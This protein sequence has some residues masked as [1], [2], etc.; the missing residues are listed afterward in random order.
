MSVYALAETPEFG[1]LSPK[2]A[3]FLMCYVQGF[4]NT[5]SFDFIDAV[6]S[7]YKTKNRES[8]RTFGYQLLSNPKI[9]ATLERFFGG[10]SDQ[11]SLKVAMTKEDR[12]CKRLLKE[13]EANLEEAEPGSTAAQKLLMQKQRLLGITFLPGRRPFIVSAE[14]SEAPRKFAVGDVVSQKGHTGRVVS[15]D[16]SGQP[17]KVELIQ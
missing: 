11:A 9:V 7:A 15:V 17:T 3:T 1:K 16:A 6:Q 5:G 13:V 2:M 8:A 14:P 12:K 10:D 4:I